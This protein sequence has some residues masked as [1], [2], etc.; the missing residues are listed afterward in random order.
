MPGW[1]ETEPSEDR[2]TERVEANEHTRL[3][4]S[5]RRPACDEPVG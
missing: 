4:P 5:R 3:G 2:R 1:R